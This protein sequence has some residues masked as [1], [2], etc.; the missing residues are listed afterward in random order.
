MRTVHG[1]LLTIIAV[2]LFFSLASFGQT[3]NLMGDVKGADGKP[4]VGAQIRIERTDIKNTYNVK[5]DKNGHFLYANLPTG[6]YNVTLVVSGKDTQQLAGLHPKQGD[7]PPLNFDLSKPPVATAV[8]ATPAELA[9]LEA[10]RKE[11]EAAMAADKALQEAFNAGMQAKAAKNWDTAVDNL[12]KASDIAPK[13]PVVWGNLGEVYLAR[14]DSKKGSD[15]DPD[16]SASMAAYSKAIDLEPTNA[17]YHNNYAR[18]LAHAKKTDQA[19]EEAAKAAQL[20]P[21]QA[22]N[23]YYN[24][25]TLFVNM[26]SGDL[27]EQ[28]F[29][30][31]IE[32]D[33]NFADAYYQYG[34]ALIGKATVGAD[35]KISAPPGTVEAFQKY[36]SLKPTGQ[37]ADTAKAMLDSMGSAVKT[38]L[39]NRSKSGKK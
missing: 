4:L 26:G 1:K 3:S 30:K 29:K 20:D 12:K 15:Q 6:V 13:Q 25:G 18:S 14:A 22:G 35:N 37:D 7:N 2:A 32:A 8:A 31:S 11:Q 21:L 36:L 39:D 24:L 16:L 23:F 9:A 10:R 5:T 17:V 27:S 33:P 38:T 34:I 19:W 28:A